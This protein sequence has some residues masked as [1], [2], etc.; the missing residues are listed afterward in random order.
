ML[1]HYQ[2]QEFSFFFYT[3]KLFQNENGKQMGAKYYQESREMLQRKACEN[4][5]NIFEEGKNKKHE[6]SMS[7]ISIEN[8]YRK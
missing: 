3:E 7:V 5:Q 6:S 4:Y 8:F 2:A 1:L